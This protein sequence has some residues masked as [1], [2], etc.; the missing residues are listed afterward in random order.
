MRNSYVYILANKRNGTLYIGVTTDLIRRISEHKRDL[1][2]GFTK[3]YCCHQLVY[4]EEHD[5]V[6][7]A[8]VREK[9]MKEWK[10]K[11]KLELI[12]KTNPD[13]KDLWDDLLNSG[14]RLSPE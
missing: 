6:E 2:G 9:N 1:I 12:E 7:Q 14:F 3:K 8:I 13:W 11:W 10:R 5:S 4:F